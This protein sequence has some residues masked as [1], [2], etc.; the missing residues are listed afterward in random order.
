MGKEYHGFVFFVP[1]PQHTCCHTPPDNERQIIQDFH[2]QRDFEPQSKEIATAMSFT[3]TTSSETCLQTRNTC[4]EHKRN[5]ERLL[6]P[7]KKASSLCLRFSLATSMT[8]AQYVPL[9]YTPSLHVVRFL[10]LHF[11]ELLRQDL[12]R[13]QGAL[14]LPPRPCTVSAAGHA[15]F[16]TPGH[17]VVLLQLFSKKKKRRRNA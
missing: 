15:S 14:L 8:T 7:P 10:F 17:S 1:K 13:E 11:F 4:N 3:S 6:P 12:K 5:L 16:Q 9:R 2:A